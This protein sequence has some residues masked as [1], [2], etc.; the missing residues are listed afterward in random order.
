ML[1]LKLKQ[2]LEIVFGKVNSRKTR[3]HKVPSWPHI[4]GKTEKNTEKELQ[5]VTNILSFLSVPPTPYSLLVLV[6]FIEF[7]DENDNLRNHD[8]SVAHTRTNIHMC[9]MVWYVA[10]WVVAR[11]N[12]EYVSLHS[13]LWGGG[14]PH[15]G[16]SSLLL[17]TFPLAVLAPKWKYLF[18]SL[19]YAMFSLVLKRIYQFLV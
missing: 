9:T 8:K 16:V 14:R 6:C 1:E 19:F 3:A 11:C 5:N 2:K 15:T 18:P 12:S 4:G 7:R 13:L 10:K 17:G